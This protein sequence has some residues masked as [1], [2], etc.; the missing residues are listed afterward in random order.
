VVA[1]TLVTGTALLGISLHVEPGDQSFY[2]FTVLV[3]AVWVVGGRL[4][5]PVRLG[6]SAGGGP[7]R[8]LAPFGVGLALGGAFLVGAFVVRAIPPLRSYVDHVLAHANSGSTL[9]VLG[10]TVLNGVAE[11]VFFRGA[12]YAAVE[13]TRPVLVSTVVYA[14]ATLA[15][16]NPMLVFAAVT[17][18]AVLGLLRRRTGGILAPAITH[19]TWS[20]LMLFALPPLFGG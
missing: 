2:L 18:G 12:L 6:G 17:V 4:S 5:G 1:V 14:L 9:A 11:E 19:V 15:T 20:T 8:L 10:V 16:G 13:R 3:A 7:R